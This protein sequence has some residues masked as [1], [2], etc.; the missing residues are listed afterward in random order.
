MKKVLILLATYNGE[1]YLQQQLDSLYRQSGAE[2]EILVRDDGSSDGTKEILRSNQSSEA[3]SCVLTW[4]E[5]EHSGAAR[6]YLE[7]MNRASEK[8]ADYYAF[9]DQDDVWDEDKLE[10]AINILDSDA[11][12]IPALYYCGQRLVDD[13]L[14]LIAD[15]TL[16]RERDL[17]ARFIL[18]DFAGCTGVFNRALLEEAIKYD[19]GYLLMHDT[20][21]LK[22]CLGLGGTVHIDPDCHISYRQHRDSTLG[23]GRSLPAYLRQVRQ[24]LNVY[25]VEP[26]MRELLKGYG[27]RLVSPYRE[28]A[29]TVCSYRTDREARSYLKDKR[30]IDYRNRGLNLTYRLKILLNRL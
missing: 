8:P 5:G 4:Y 24:Y 19:P 9:C 17:K 14:N 1:K 25:M 21:I 29:E 23:L 27:D 2:V 30:N 13:K 15:H 6:G 16:N 18:S 28:L 22:I 20:W 7:L 26:Q 10:T 3:G 11:P 12:N